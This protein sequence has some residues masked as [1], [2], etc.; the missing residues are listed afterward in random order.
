MRRSRS[1]RTRLLTALMLMTL[2]TLGIATGLSAVMDLKLFRDHMLRDLQVLAAVTAENCISSL[3]FDSPET[4]ERNLATLAREYQVRSAI[5]YDAGDRPFARW[6]RTAESTPRTAAPPATIAHPLSYDGSP[7]GRLV[8]NVRLEEL[9]R[10]MR[11]YFWLVAVLVLSTAAIAFAVALWLQRRLTRPI[12]ELVDAT[13]R[14]GERQDFSLRVEAPRAEREIESLVHGFNRMLGQ[15]EQRQGEL[16]AANAALRRLATDLSLLEQTEKARLAGE[17]HDGP[18]QKLALAQI[19]MDAAA[20]GARAPGADMGEVEQQRAAGIALMREALAELRTLQFDLS[21]PV[22]Q[23]RGLAAALHWLAGSTTERWGI[24]MACEVDDDLPDLNR[25][26]SLI[27][28][29][30]ARE[31]VYNVI[32]HAKAR[33]GWIALLADD[34]SSVVIRVEDDGLGFEPAAARPVPAETGGYGLYSVRERVSLLGGR[35]DVQSGPGGSRVTIR[36]PSSVKAA[37]PD[38][39]GAGRDTRRPGAAS[40]K[41]QGVEARDPSLPGSASDDG[42]DDTAL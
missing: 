8:L 40:L 6:Q 20:K 13:R 36:L 37:Y 21:P 41:P 30:C 42:I 9:Q 10:Q 12:L 35:V 7:I 11:S 26:Q 18:M 15:I 2:L 3:V 23:T 5:L 1:I 38:G 32:K 34:E 4:A 27:L 14:V 28:F 17:L 16:D 24:A 19:Q 22:L 39:D 33:N 25:Q 29:Q 31:L